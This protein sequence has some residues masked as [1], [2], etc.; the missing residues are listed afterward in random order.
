MSPGDNRVNEQ[1]V[2]ATLQTYFVRDHNRIAAELSLINPHWDDE[3]VYQVRAGPENSLAAR[4]QRRIVI[5]SSKIFRKAM[6]T[7]HG[8]LTAGF[9]SMILPAQF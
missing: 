4:D 2:L 6:D 9:Q 5:I 8:V 3:T 7:A 1:L